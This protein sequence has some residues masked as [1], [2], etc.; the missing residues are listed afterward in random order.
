MTT[1]KVELTFSEGAS[2]K[3]WRAR[4]EDGTLFVNY[5]RIGSDGQTQVKNLGSAAAAEKELDKLEKEKRKKGYEDGTSSAAAEDEEEEEGEEEEEE[6]EEEKPKKKAAPAPAAA[7]PPKVGAAAI[8]SAR[9]KP[10]RIDH[11]DYAVTIE[12]RTVDLRLTL[13]GGTVRTVVVERYATPE[14]AEQA[15]GRLKTQMVADGYQ[16]VPARDSL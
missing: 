5:G 6:E 1:W 15:Y 14:E 11:A 7:A 16:P 2:N 12:G 8:A 10:T 13:E 9:A 4:T 3:F